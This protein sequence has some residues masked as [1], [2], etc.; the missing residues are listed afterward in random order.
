MI[1]AYVFG[2][3][4][5]NTEQISSIQNAYVYLQNAK[6]LTNFNYDGTPLLEYTSYEQFEYVNVEDQSALLKYTYSNW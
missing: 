4:K 5:W 6:F 3:A 1:N 2:N